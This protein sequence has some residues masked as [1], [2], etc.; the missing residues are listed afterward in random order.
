M[1]TA[2]MQSII[3]LVAFLIFVGIVGWAWSGRRREAFGEAARI[4]LDDD[5]PFQ[6]DSLRRGQAGDGGP[7]GTTG[8]GSTEAR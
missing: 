4:P 3:T 5:A 1:T 2:D 6:A 7:A 8:T